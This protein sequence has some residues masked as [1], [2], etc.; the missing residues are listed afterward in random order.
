MAGILTGKV[1]GFFTFSDCASTSMLL[2][3]QCSSEMSSLGQS[4]GRIY[5]ILQLN[6]SVP[7]VIGQADNKPALSQSSSYYS[8]NTSQIFDEVL[9]TQRQR[10]LIT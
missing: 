5:R 10:G 6:V 9:S 8:L 3:R 4:K 1:Q 2:P 7:W